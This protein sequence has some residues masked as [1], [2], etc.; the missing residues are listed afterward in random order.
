MNGGTAKNKV[1][2]IDSLRTGTLEI[3]LEYGLQD[4]KYHQG[5]KRVCGM[6]QQ[7]QKLLR[8]RESHYG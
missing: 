3:Q 7:I 6:G 4:K 1:I 8:S 5:Y 2:K